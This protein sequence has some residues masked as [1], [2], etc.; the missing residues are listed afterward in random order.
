MMPNP[1]AIY[2]LNI[3][4]DGDYLNDLAF[5]YVFSK[6]QNGRQTV[7]VFVA[8]GQESRSVEVV[9][10]KIIADG[11]VSFGT[12]P[13]IIKSGP[14]TFF[15]GSRSDAFFFDFD[16]IKN[17]FDTRGKRNLTEPHLAGKSPRA[18]PRLRLFCLPFAGGGASSYRTWADE[19]PSHIEVMP[20]QFPGREERFREEP[21]QRMEDLVESLVEGLLPFISNLPFAFFGH[22]LGAIVALEVTRSLSTRH[23]PMPCHLFVSARPAPHMPLRRVPVL[24]HSRE[25]IVQWLRQVGGTPELVLENRELMDLMLPVLRADLQIDDT[26]RSTADPVLTCPLTVLGGHHDEQAIPHELNAWAPYTSNS[27]ALHILQGNHFFPFN[28]SRSAALAL[29][30]DALANADLDRDKSRP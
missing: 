17:L 15:A 6:P 18:H 28:E 10:T 29:V 22:S 5:S 9:G 14:Y 21:L 25:E 8:K 2:R 24:D 23:A 16:G 19:L 3:D 12:K 4:N 20:V 27:F 1:D 26:Y 11:E 30:A 7:N 13:N